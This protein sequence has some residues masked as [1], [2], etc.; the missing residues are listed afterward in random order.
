[1]FRSDSCVYSDAYIVLNGTINR[2][3]A[4]AN[5]TDKAEKNAQK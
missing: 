3:A 1:M 2:L 4:A 5:E